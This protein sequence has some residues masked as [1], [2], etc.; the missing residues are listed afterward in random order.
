MKL[1][2]ATIHPKA[3]PTAPDPIVFLMGGPGIS[4]LGNVGDFLTRDFGSRDVILF[5]QRGSGLSQP[6]LACG[7]G[8]DAY[9]AAL[10]TGDLGQRN[11]IGASAV[12]TCHDKLVADG[13]NLSAY[14]RAADIADLEDLRVALGIDSWNV[15]GMSYGTLFA[16]EAARTHSAT[17]RSLILESVE[18]TTAQNFAPEFVT[19]GFREL[20]DGCAASSVC[21]TKYPNLEADTHDMVATLNG[22]PHLGSIKDAAGVAHPIVVT[23]GDAL[24]VIWRL[25]EAALPIVPATIEAFRAGNYAFL[26]SWFGGGIP[27]D[28]HG[29]A[30]GADVSYECADDG[31]PTDT[32]AAL[33]A[34]PEYDAILSVDVRRFCDLWNVPRLPASFREP[35][36]FDVPTLIYAGDYDP[37]TPPQSGKK[38]ADQLPHATYI[39]FPGMGHT[40]TFYG[41]DRTACPQSIMK[42]FIDAPTFSPALACVAAMGDPAWA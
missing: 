8:A 6:R 28:G 18:P 22:T 21:S 26:D 10:A 15:W 7:G 38:L 42:A 12:K 20:F 14:N 31:A 39:S 1:A 29:Y 27:G 5:D 11:A 3:G 34:H 36:T 33:R 32:D 23:G 24:G 4:A 35:V 2:V 37:N 17:M 41:G 40:P 9:F 13:I 25:Q 16:L 30:V 19:N